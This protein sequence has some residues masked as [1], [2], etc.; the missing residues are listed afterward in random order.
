MKT[1]VELKRYDDHN[2]PIGVS[3]QGFIEYYHQNKSF[4]CYDKNGELLEKI[5][6]T[7]DFGFSEFSGSIV[8]NGKSNK[9][10]LC[11][12]SISKLIVI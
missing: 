7:N 5:Q 12:Y 2:G 8:V 9:L 6:T 11:N 1:F 4:Y 10:I 3:K